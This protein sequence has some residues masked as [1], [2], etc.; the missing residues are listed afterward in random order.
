MAV[1]Q[2]FEVSAAQRFWAG[3]RG[4][5]NQHPICR[6]IAEQQ[7]PAILE[8]RDC[9]QWRLR[10]ARPR[11]PDRTSLEPEL[12]CTAQDLRDAD[13]GRAQAMTQLRLL[14][15]DA[16]NPQQHGKDKEPLVVVLGHAW[17]SIALSRP[18]SRSFG[19]RYF[20]SFRLPALFKRGDSAV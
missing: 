7:E 16:V 2:R 20:H 11:R 5:L 13:S 4:A 14:G 10:Q 6:R 8:Y 18:G 19:C 15:S 12:L 9:R 3:C 17:A 1:P